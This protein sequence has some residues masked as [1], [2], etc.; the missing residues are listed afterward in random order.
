MN[1]HAVFGQN[2]FHQG[3]TAKWENGILPLDW[4]VS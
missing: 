1:N 3:S 4:T 2:G